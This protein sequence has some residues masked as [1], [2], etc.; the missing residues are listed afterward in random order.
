MWWL[1]VLKGFMKYLQGSLRQ[2]SVSGY[3]V[4]IQGERTASAHSHVNSY[5]RFIIDRHVNV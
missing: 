3:K 4:A 2:H 5:N 1:L